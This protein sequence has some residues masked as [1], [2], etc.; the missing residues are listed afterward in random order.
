MF[1]GTPKQ[2]DIF[3]IMQTAIWKD[4]DLKTAI[5]CVKDISMRIQEVLIFAW[6]LSVLWNRPSVMFSCF[7]DAPISR[8][9]VNEEAG[10]GV[11]G[12]KTDFFPGHAL[13]KTFVCLLY[14]WKSRQAEKIYGTKFLFSKV[15]KFWVRS[16]TLCWA[17]H[18]NMCQTQQ[19]DRFESTQI[20]SSSKERSEEL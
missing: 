17:M 14:T 9:N 15:L 7:I 18:P 20:C 12:Y 8:L 1:Y 4:L 2:L 19:A 13:F 5:Y 16:R 3:E 6:E 10:T 11:S